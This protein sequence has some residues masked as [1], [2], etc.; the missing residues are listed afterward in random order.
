MIFKFDY[1]YL[2]HFIWINPVQRIILEKCRSRANFNLSDWAMCYGLNCWAVKMFMY[3]MH[4]LHGKL[5]FK[6]QMPTHSTI[7]IVV[8]TLIFDAL[9]VSFTFISYQFLFE[10]SLRGACMCVCAHNILIILYILH[11]KNTCFS[12]LLHEWIC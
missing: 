3:T 8:F 9:F 2:A 4:Q 11:I 7:L 12:C 5:V 10:L 1:F 6:M